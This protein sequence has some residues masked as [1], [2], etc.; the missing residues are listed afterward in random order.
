M[1]TSDIKLLLPNLT[2]V[3][4]VMLFAV[5]RYYPLPDDA[6][7]SEDAAPRPFANPSQAKAK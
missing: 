2:F 5:F 7:V 4:S 6:A 3:L 1:H